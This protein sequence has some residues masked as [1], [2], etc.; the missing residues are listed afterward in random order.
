MYSNKRVRTYSGEYEAK[1]SSSQPMDVYSPWNASSGRRFY[2]RRFPTTRRV[3]RS[4]VPPSIRTNVRAVISSMAEKKRTAYTWSLTPQCLQNASGTLTNNYI[5]MN[6]SNSGNGYSISTGATQGDMIG[7]KIRLSKATLT[8]VLT[9]LP[10]NVS[11]NTNPQ[12]LVAR[13]FFFKSKAT[14]TTAITTAQLTANATANFFESTSGN[15]TNL[16][17]NSLDMM[18][19]INSDAFTYLGHRDVKVSPQQPQGA[20]S[21]PVSFY[22]NNDFSYYCKFTMDVTRMLP[23]VQTKQDNNTWSEPWVYCLLQVIAADQTY[24]PISTGQQICNWRGV[25]NYEYTDV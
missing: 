19:K 12:P 11:T 5:V 16:S 7:N 1:N 4:R 13:F 17:G 15:D 24:G 23:R 10:Y 9:Q 21:V 14:P 8:S 6:P 18:L 3:Y 25:L 22:T 2:R 20:S